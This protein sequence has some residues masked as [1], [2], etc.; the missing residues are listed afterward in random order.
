MNKQ[1]PCNSICNSK[2]KYTY[3]ILMKFSHLDWQ[4]SL[5]SQSS[6]NNT[7][8]E[9]APS[10]LL[11][12]TFQGPMKA[13]NSCYFLCCLLESPSPKCWRQHAHQIQGPEV[14]ELKLI[15]ISSSWVPEGF[16]Q[17]P[18]GRGNKLVILPT[19]LPTNHNKS[20]PGEKTHKCTGVACI[21]WR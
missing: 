8:H 12:G 18:E 5:Q 9:H 21:P 19:M 14:P 10:A 16:M 11:E 13:Y 20:Q 15:W 17:V 7:R 4:S 3:T 6:P 1:S 2:Y